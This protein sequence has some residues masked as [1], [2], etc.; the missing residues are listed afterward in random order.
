MYTGIRT[1]ETDPTPWKTKQKKQNKQVKKGKKKAKRKILTWE[2]HLN[3]KADI[4]ATRAHNMLQKKKNIKNIFYPLLAAQIYLVL[5][6]TTIL[7]R[8]KE[9]TNEAWCHE[10][11][12]KHLR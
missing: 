3:I 5:N 2:A 6:K 1:Q 7:S 12:E 8:H 11:Y 10:D 9:A 4:L